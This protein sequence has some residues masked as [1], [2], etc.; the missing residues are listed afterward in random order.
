M[1]LGCFFVCKLCPGGECLLDNLR[2]GVFCNVP[3]GEYL[4]PAADQGEGCAGFARPSG[5]ADP[6]NI[7]LV[8][9]GQ[10]VVEYY[11]DAAY[12]NAPGC[13]VRGNQH[14]D[15]AAFEGVHHLGALHLLHISVET[16]GLDALV[17]KRLCQL[18]HR[19]LG[20]A[21]HHGGSG[22]IGQKQKPESI[23]FSAHGSFVVVLFDGVHGAVL[24]GNFNHGG[25]LLELLGD[26]HDLRGHGGRK[27]HGLALLRYAGEDG[28][29][30]FP[31]AHIE[32]FVRLVQNHGFQI[33]QLEGAPVH[34][35]HDPSRCAH[36]NICTPFEVA[37][38][39]IHAGAAV[40][41]TGPYPGHEAGKLFQ[42][43]AGLHGKLTG[44]AEDQHLY[45]VAVILADGLH[46]GNAECGGFAGAGVG[47]ADEIHALH[48]Q[49]NALFL[50][51]CHFCK[52][53][54]CDSIQQG[55]GKWKLTEL[56]V[57][58]F[59]SGDC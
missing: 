55:L 28:F 40:Y 35:V 50:D 56:H 22:L 57:V 15:S 53:H 10:I 6:V 54:L 34:M 31:E 21:E 45:A 17:T 18:V 39:P 4:P 1:Q 2:L 25:I 8:V 43:L 7:I 19:A 3:Q 11:I 59:R 24:C 58:S 5:S 30:V 26:G 44:G 13:Y 47:S 27:Q 29:N 51:F 14:P 36:H 49:R 16:G 41:R 12:V 48:H 46:G 52:T 23:G 38:L 20:I 42:L 33:L 32:H 37:D 9:L